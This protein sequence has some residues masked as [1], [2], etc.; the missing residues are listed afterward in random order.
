MKADYDGNCNWN[1]Q[2]EAGQRPAEGSFPWVEAFHQGLQEG[3]L[4]Q[5]RQPA[6]LDVFLKKVR[7]GFD[8]N[9]LPPK[10]PV[11]S[12]AE[13]MAKVNKI[14]ILEMVEALPYGGFG[15]VQ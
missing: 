12:V 9:I 3:D 4:F 1:R 2:G 7:A 15:L 13:S 11:L 6:K 5:I 14:A 10:R 8:D